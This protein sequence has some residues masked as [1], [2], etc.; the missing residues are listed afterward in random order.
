VDNGLNCGKM[1]GLAAREIV[2]H[3]KAKYQNLQTTLK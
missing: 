1:N 3:I 2:E